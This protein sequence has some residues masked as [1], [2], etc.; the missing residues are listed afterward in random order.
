MINRRGALVAIGLAGFGRIDW[1]ISAKH[2]LRGLQGAQ[3]SFTAFGA[4]LV[5]ANED[6][7]S[8]DLARL[9]AHVYSEE[10]IP[11][12]LACENLA[13]IGTSPARPPSP[14]ALNKKVASA[15]QR[16]AYEWQRVH[17]KAPASD[18]AKIV[19]VLADQDFA[20]GGME[21]T[22]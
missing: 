11:M 2:R 12:F 3:T 10:G 1:L 20:D 21:S 7:V 13:P 15:F 6:K 9:G 18:V 8:A 14:S 22:L 17:P 5:N 19:E 4:E 16:Y